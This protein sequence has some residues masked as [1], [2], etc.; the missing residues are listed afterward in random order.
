MGIKEKEHVV[1]FLEQIKGNRLLPFFQRFFK[2]GPG[3]LKNDVDLENK[4]AVEES[5]KY[6]KLYKKDE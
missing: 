2:W 1:Y 4:A 3:S 5:G 6:C